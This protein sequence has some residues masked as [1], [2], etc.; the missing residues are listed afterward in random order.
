MKEISY[1]DG[2]YTRLM[3]LCGE[4]LKRWEALQIENPTWEDV[5]LFY[6]IKGI[7]SRITQKDTYYKI[8]PITLKIAS[9]PRNNYRPLNK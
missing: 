5:Q 8:K 2:K 7:F 3:Q 1:K 6:N 4:E 9:V